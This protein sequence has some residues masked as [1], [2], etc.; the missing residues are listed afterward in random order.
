MTEPLK[1]KERFIED[2]RN[3]SMNVLL[4]N[5]VY[6]HLS[7]SNNGS[8]FYQ[9]DIITFPDHLT[10]CGDMG[11]LTFRRTH[12][13]FNF[14]SKFE[15]GINPYYWSEKIEI[16]EGSPSDIIKELESDENIEA[17]LIKEFKEWIDDLVEDGEDVDDEEDLLEEMIEHAED[18]LFGE[19]YHESYLYSK[20]DDF[21]FTHNDNTFTFCMDEGIPI[22]HRKYKDRYLWLCWAITWAIQEF[23]KQGESNG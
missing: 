19:I 13:M 2:T 7:F 6:R 9:F 5:G 21:T 15:D 16:L 10:I 11:T 18:E 4:D 3:H 23:N 22:A 17:E 1:S 12:D 14:F 8:S 20:M